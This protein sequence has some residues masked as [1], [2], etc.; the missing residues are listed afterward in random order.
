MN[1]NTQHNTTQNTP[2]RS[3][4]K[5]DEE[6]ERREKKKEEGKNVELT[7][8]C[9]TMCCGAVPFFVCLGFVSFFLTPSAPC[10]KSKFC[11]FWEE[12]GR[13]VET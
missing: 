3:N 8:R 10:E 6:E 2:H 4:E 7:C 9:D 5:R 12:Y 13:S 1:L 11:V